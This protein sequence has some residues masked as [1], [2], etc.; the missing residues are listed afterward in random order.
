MIVTE[1]GWITNTASSEVCL[2]QVENP[3]TV[4]RLETIRRNMP[5]R[6]QGIMLSINPL[7]YGFLLSLSN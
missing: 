7:D 5:Q 4:Q 2:G 6:F 3:R 1:V